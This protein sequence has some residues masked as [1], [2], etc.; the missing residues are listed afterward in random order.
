MYVY[1]ATV[2]QME[3]DR[4]V[5]DPSQTVLTWSESLIEG[6]SIYRGDNNRWAAGG[7]K[8]RKNAPKCTRKSFET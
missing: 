1:P 3:I 5:K 2:A 7:K 4:H 6:G 8:M